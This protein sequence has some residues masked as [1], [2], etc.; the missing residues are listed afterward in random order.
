MR[1]LLVGLSLTITYRLLNLATLSTV[2]Y[3]DLQNQHCVVIIC[4]QL[5]SVLRRTNKHTLQSA[6]TTSPA[7]RQPGSTYQLLPQASQTK[8]SIRLSSLQDI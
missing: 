1:L 3:P 2:T 5:Q 7:E 8:C 4:F 6:G